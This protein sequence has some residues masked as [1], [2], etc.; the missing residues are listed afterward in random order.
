MIDRRDLVFGAGA[1]AAAAGAAALYPRRRLNLVGGAR[2]ETMIPEQFG[3]WRED[4][5]VGVVTPPSEGSLADRLYDEIFSRAYI[6]AGAMLPVM[7][8]ITHG[9]SQ[10]DALQLHRPEACYPAVGF[11]IIGRALAS[12]PLAPSIALPAVRLTARLGNRTEDILYWT[13]VGEYFPQTGGAQRN[14]RIKAAL[15]GYVGDGILARV[16]AIRTDEQAQFARL[17]RFARDLVIAIPRHQ[18]RALIGT[19]RAQMLT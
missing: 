6:E 18:R 1:F 3:I 8:L 9:A 12:L 4:P 2:L 16:S 17:D 14:D 5:N 13:R 7:A 11:A 15:D 19:Q 10:S